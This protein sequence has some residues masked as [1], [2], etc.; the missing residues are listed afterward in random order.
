MMER[1]GEGWK[2]RKKI[3]VN[4]NK[5]LY[6]R[7]LE[8][9]MIMCVSVLTGKESINHIKILYKIFKQKCLLSFIFNFRKPGET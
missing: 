5:I 8:K 2:G 7:Q 6:E 4:I 1:N 3:N 9:C